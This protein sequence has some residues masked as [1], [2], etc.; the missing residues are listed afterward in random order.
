MRLDE[1][2]DAGEW[3]APQSASGAL[4]E[5]S[6]AHVGPQPPLVLESATEHGLAAVTEGVNSSFNRFAAARAMAS[7]CSI[8]NPRTR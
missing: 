7:S 1:G 4:D 6:T 2:P 5:A 3:D 8:D